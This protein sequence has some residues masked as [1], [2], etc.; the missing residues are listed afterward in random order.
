MGAPV[1]PEWAFKGRAPL[2]SR[3]I[4]PLTCSSYTAS[5]CTRWLGRNKLSG[6]PKTAAYAP[7]SCL[8]GDRARSCP[9]TNCGAD[10]IPLIPATYRRR[11]PFLAFFFAFLAGLRAAFFLAAFLAAF[12]LAGLLAAFFGAFFF[13]FLAAFFLAAGL[14]APPPPPAGAGL[15]AEGAGV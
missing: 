12:F 8:S 1:Q 14:R 10:K 15:G 11:P 9:N 6:R 4:T 7:R 13:A 3:R 2:R 5:A